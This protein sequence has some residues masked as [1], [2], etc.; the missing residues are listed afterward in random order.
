MEDYDGASQ[1]PLVIGVCGHTICGHCST[2]IDRCPFC[3]TAFDKQDLHKNYALC[4]I[5]FSMAFLSIKER[6]P[7]NP[8]E[9]K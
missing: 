3:K 4:S 2:K 8:L 5:I 1:Q 6:R 9:I 7:R